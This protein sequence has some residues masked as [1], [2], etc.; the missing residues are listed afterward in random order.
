MLLKRNVKLSA[1]KIENL[2]YEK[3]LDCK[4]S[5]GKYSSREWS[6]RAYQTPDLMVEWQA[7]TSTYQTF[8]CALQAQDM[9]ACN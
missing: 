9:P 4:M 7:F 3:S 6:V 2:G 8:P 5:A 1:W